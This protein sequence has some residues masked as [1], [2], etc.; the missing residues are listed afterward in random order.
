MDR[1]DPAYRG[2]ADYSPLLLKLYD[3]I[4]IGVVAGL[5][6]RFPANRLPDEYRARIRD[7]HLD[8]GPGTGYLIDHS[9]I[10]DGSHVTIVD[11]NPNVLRH[12]TRRLR[13]LNVT[14]VEAD[15]LKPLPVDGPFDS[16]ALSLVIHCLPGPLTRKATAVA[17][18]AAVLAPDG[19]LFGASVLGRSGQ[20]T[21]SVVGSSP[22]STGAAPSTTSMTARKVSAR[23]SPPPSRAWRWR[24]SGRSWSSPRRN[25]GLGGQDAIR[26]SAVSG[27]LLRLGRPSCRRPNT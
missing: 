23:S 13:R 25:R 12:A 14:A 24:R 17:N 26:R 7:R 10:P 22:R 18:I 5:V 2:Q 11:P 3:P 8:V 15:V 6:W 19:V 27:D 16:A 4:V 21:G 20:H 1:S 9:G